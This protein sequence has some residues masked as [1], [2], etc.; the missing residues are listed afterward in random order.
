MIIG[1]SD[2]LVT[3]KDAKKAFDEM[4]QSIGKTFHTYDIGF[5]NLCDYIRAHVFYLG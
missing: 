2:R 1:T 4:S 5:L 3:V